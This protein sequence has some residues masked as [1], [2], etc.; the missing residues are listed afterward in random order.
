MQQRASHTNIDI[1]EE[2]RRDSSA[3]KSLALI[4][5]IFLPTTALAVSHISEI[6]TMSVDFNMAQR[7]RVFFSLE[8]LLPER[9]TTLIPG[10][11]IFSVSSFFSPSPDGS[12]RVVVSSQFWIF[13]AVAAPITLV[14]VLIWFVWI[15]RK[16]VRSFRDSYRQSLLSNDVEAKTDDSSSDANERSRP[17]QA[18]RPTMRRDRTWRDS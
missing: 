14:I 16:Q 15:N 10:Q 2:T 17:M 13:W 3:M 12:G 11:T 4:T 5:T 8:T 18:N 7:T 6:S 9:N 1:A